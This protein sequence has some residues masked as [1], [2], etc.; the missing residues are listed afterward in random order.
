MKFRS[1]SAKPR[2]AAERDARKEE[3][4]RLREEVTAAQA[5]MDQVNAEQE[6]SAP[7]HPQSHPSGRSAGHGTCR[8]GPCA[9]LPVPAFDFPPRD[10]VEI[11]EKLDLMDF[12]AAAK[13]AGHGFY[14]LKNEAVL[15]E[16][17]LQLFAVR[18]VIEAG[19]TPTTTPDLARNEVLEG[20]G[21]I[22]RAGNADLQ[23]RGERLEP[24]GDRRDHA[25][26]HALRTGARYR[27]SA[28]E[29][30]RH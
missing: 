26:R 23:H 29:I 11:G 15:L 28:A 27:R 10:H 8:G 30:V 17:A 21:F 14:F 16:L 20:I 3:G 18:T 12:E 22:P 1:R 5:E 4:R 2:T 25:R 7:R 9:Q 6:P 24:G 19:F 13:V